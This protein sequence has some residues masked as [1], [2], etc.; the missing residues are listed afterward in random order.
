MYLLIRHEISRPYERALQVLWKLPIFDRY[1]AQLGVG[2]G[3]N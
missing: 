3:T 2:A 1:V